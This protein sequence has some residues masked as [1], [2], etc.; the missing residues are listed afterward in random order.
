MSLDFHSLKSAFKE[1]HTSEL[2]K[3]AHIIFV[4]S[5]VF[6]LFI[7]LEF[8]PNFP[9]KQLKNSAF[10]FSQLTALILSFLY[11]YTTPKQGVVTSLWVIA[12]NFLARHVFSI[13]EDKR[14]LFIVSFVVSLS[15]L[16]LQFGSHYVGE[17]KMPEKV[18]RLAVPLAPLMITDLLMDRVGLGED[19]STEGKRKN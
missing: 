13:F 3:V 4:P 12:F 10:N 9:I 16:L 2:T 5:F 7:V 11:I 8:I 15:S 14:S 6:F 17:P 19:G 1:H 18:D